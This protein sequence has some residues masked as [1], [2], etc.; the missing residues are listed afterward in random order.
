[1]AELPDDTP[2]VRRRTSRASRR[3]RFVLPTDHHDERVGEVIEAFLDGPPAPARRTRRAP[4]PTPLHTVRRPIPL[5]TR[6]DW[7]LALRYEDARLARYGRPASVVVIRLRL[8]PPG[9]EDRL[10]SRVGEIVRE[11]ARETDRVTRAAADRFH[12]LLPETEEAEAETLL[13]R[14]RH[15]CAEKVVGRL[16]AELR[17]VGAAASP[18]D[19]E[20]LLDALR[21]AQVAV[22]AA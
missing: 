18:G 6:P 14:M 5:D 20:T 12:V 4:R 11:H 3:T 9:S 1:M 13:E 17:L 19:G 16:G 8:A 2:P 7:D 10:A 21:A 22:G 15:A